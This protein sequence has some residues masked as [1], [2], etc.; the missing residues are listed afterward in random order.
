MR[1]FNRLKEDIKNI[2]ATTK[3]M[4]L[5]INNATIFNGEDNIPVKYAV[6]KPITTIMTDGDE[7]E[8]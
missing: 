1:V 6:E 5:E 2:G 4:A 7:N 8:R 3:T